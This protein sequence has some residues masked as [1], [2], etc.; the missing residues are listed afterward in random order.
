LGASGASG[1]LGGGLGASGA[2]GALGGGFGASGAFGGDGGLGVDGGLGALGGLKFGG[3]TL[4][5]SGIL[6]L[7][8]SL[9]NTRIEIISICQQSS[10]QKNVFLTFHFCNYFHIHNYT[11]ATP[12]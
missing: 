9:Y 3:F 8:I 10:R 7:G 4:G 1:A 6:N 2:S 11:N 12:S 5:T